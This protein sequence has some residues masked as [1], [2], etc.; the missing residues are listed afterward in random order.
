MENGIFADGARLEQV[1]VAAFESARHWRPPCADETMKPTSESLSPVETRYD[2]VAEAYCVAVMRGGELA[3]AK[4]RSQTKVNP[5]RPEQRASR[6]GSRIC[7]G[8][9]RGA[10]AKPGP[11]A[12]PTPGGSRVKAGGSA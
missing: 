9:P 7:R 5:I 11:M 4:D 6:R 10:L 1:S 3:E 8:K 12:R 2:C